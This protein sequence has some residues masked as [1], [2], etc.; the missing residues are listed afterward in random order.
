M[1]K[2]VRFLIWTAL[3]VGALVG[4]SRA[5]AIRWYRLPTAEEDPYLVASVAPT[6]RGGDLI[7]LWRLTPP[8]L[9]DLVMCPDPEEPTRIVIGRIVGEENDRIRVED[10]NL[11]VNDKRAG[12]ERA[13]YPQSFETENPSS[14]RARSKWSADTRTCA[15][16]C[17]P[18]ATRPALTPRKSRPHMCI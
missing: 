12:T 9:G 18:G 17:L 1:H 4:V 16:R 5:T 11:Y 3:L 14:N 7:L 8:E 2:W 10:S 15:A 13:C 6:L